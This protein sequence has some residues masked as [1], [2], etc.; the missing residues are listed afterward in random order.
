M[1][2][3]EERRWDP[4]SSSSSSS[5]IVVRRR[6]VL[7]L[8]RGGDL[9]ARI[10]DLRREVYRRENPY[11]LRPA[12]GRH[13]AEDELDER[14]YH[15]CALEDEHVVSACRFTPCPGGRWELSPEL[16]LP[17]ELAADAPLLLQA[18]RVVVLDERRRQRC[19]EALTGYAC[20]WL[21]DNTPFRG[22]FAL[23]T[24]VH[25]RYYRH[26]GAALVPGP[27]VTVSGRGDN[28]YRFI[29]GDL[30]ATADVTAR[31][32]AERDGL[33][34]TAPRPEPV[35]EAPGRAPSRS[36]AA[37]APAHSPPA[38]PGAP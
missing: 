12:P 28:R 16:P 2:H 5:S 3:T 32:L 38:T 35:R 14:S 11:L 29:R 22:Y 7:R 8:A 17:E 30:A 18:S 34:V 31:F 23:C 36:T 20:R 6:P 27:V 25:V 24:P 37:A 9:L 33:P 15:F 4:S 26:F 21:A 1:T 19:A 10:Y 13:P